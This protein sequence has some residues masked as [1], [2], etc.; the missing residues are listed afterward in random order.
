MT[1]PHAANQVSVASFNVAGFEIA[2][3]GSGFSLDDQ[4]ALLNRMRPDLVCFQEM[5]KDAQGQGAYYPNE[6]RVAKMA[7]LLSLS[8]TL[9]S[10][11]ADDDLRFPPLNMRY[12]LAILSRW[13]LA[14]PVTYQLPQ[15]N[16]KPGY[17]RILLTAVVSPGNGMPP[18]RIATVHLMHSPQGQ[19]DRVAQAEFINAQFANEPNFFI[20]GGDYNA[21]SDSEEIR[22]LLDR[23]G[24]TEAIDSGIDK[25]LYRGSEHWAVLQT[26]TLPRNGASDHDPIQALFGYSGPDVKSAKNA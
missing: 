22:L 17:P 14:D 3:G 13:P 15:V 18:F 16:D 6:D 26:R 4:A 10:K 23:G 1:L 25:I 24:W 5:V 8:Y 11:P 12:G 9:Y 2:K 7:E 20:M 21:R 19:E